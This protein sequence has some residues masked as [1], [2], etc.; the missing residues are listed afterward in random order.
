MVEKIKKSVLIV[1]ADG[2][3][4]KTLYKEGSKF[5]S[6]SGT[7]KKDLDITDK[8]KIEDKC[9]RVNPCVIVLTAAYTDVDGCEKNPE[10]ADR[11]NVEGTKNVAEAARQLKVPLIFISSDYVFD[12]EKRLSYREEDK[13]GPISV[14]GRSKLDG[15]KIVQLTLK[16]SVIIRSSWLFGEGGAGF[17]PFVLNAL[18]FKKPIQVVSDKI[19]SPTYVVDLSAAIRKIIRLIIEGKYDFK[20]N[21]ILH[22]ANSGACSWLDIAEFIVKYFHL[23]N[24][25]FET[26]GLSQFP[27]KAKRP[28]YSALDNTRYNQLVQESLRPWQEALGEFLQ[29]QK[30]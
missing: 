16:E 1:G 10:L 7:T 24:V 3:L 14:Y 4:G 2:L 23:K 15:E 13:P 19:G 8:T 9:R 18:R 28:K 30:I 26:I 6:I 25:K 12:G 20:K 5:F 29:C 11:I 27:F 22:I 21:K 17:V